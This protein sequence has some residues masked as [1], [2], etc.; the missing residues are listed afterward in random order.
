[1]KWELS[2]GT[3]VHLG[4]RVRG[5]SPL[6]ALLREDVALIKSGFG[7][8]V[9]V[10]AMPSPPRRVDLDDAQLVNEWVRWRVRRFRVAVTS[11]PALAPIERLNPP[12]PPGAT[13]E[14][15]Y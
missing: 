14:T 1:M 15:I 12:L 2:D 9:Q 10:E 13:D 4:G 5:S 7:V 3:E 8:T 6:A 11:A